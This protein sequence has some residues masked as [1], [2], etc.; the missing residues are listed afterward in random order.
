MFKASE[1]IEDVELFYL[2]ED[3][4]KIAEHV[5]KKKLNVAPTEKLLKI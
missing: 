3:D 2:P 4:R 5:C 1:E